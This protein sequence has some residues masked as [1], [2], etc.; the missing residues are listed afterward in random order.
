[1]IRAKWL[2]RAAIES[3]NLTRLLSQG[4]LFMSDLSFKV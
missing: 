2:Q 1:M 3:K 4:L